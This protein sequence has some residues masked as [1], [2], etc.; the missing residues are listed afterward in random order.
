MALQ[1]L[2]GLVLD[3]KN[4]RQRSQ[5]TGGPLTISSVL[6]AGLLKWLKGCGTGEVQLRNLPWQLVLQA[7]KK[8]RLRHTP[9]HLCAQAAACQCLI[10]LCSTKAL[11]QGF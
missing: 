3:I 9:M 11:R 4:N 7:D 6:S 1:V 10:M 2:L 5:G 8:V